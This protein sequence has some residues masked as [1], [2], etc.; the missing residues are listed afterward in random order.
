MKRIDFAVTFVA[1]AALAF[2]ASVGAQNAPTTR[3]PMSSSP[4][5]MSST[6]SNSRLSAQADASFA[7]DAATGGQSEVKLGQLAQQKGSNEAVKQFG[8]KMVTDHSTAGDKLK[9]I[10]S[11]DGI[12]VSDAP[13]SEGQ[14]EYD[15]LSQLSGKDFDRAYANDMVQDHQQDIAKFKQEAGSGQNPDL[16][17]F[18]S[19]TLPTLQ[20]H[21]QMAQQMQKSVGAQ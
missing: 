19:Q 1:F 9:T 14:A 12:T 8:Q 21:L 10:A 20:E 13:D 11:K 4:D 7:Q 6:A 3:N 15:R 5:S 2:A 16:K 18:A 17:N